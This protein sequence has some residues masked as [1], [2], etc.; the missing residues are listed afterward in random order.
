MRG[1]L[2]PRGGRFGS[3]DDGSLD[4]DEFQ[5]RNGLGIVLEPTQRNLIVIVVVRDHC[6]VSTVAVPAPT[7]RKMRMRD[8][9]L[10][11][12]C[13]HEVSAGL[14]PVGMEECSR[15]HGGREGQQRHDRDVTAHRDV[16]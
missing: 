10:R 16:L 4:Q 9:G 1:D 15:K 14:V 3:L 2:D 12:M 13:P 7:G 8:E 5:V 6:H 11:Q